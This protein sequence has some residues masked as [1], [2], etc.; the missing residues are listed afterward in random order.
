[1]KQKTTTRRSRVL[2]TLL[3]AAIILLLLNPPTTFAAPAR[4]GQIHIVQRGET[5]SSIAARYGVSLSAIT[6]ANGISNANVIYVG[7]SLT[8]PSGASGT[9]QTSPSTSPVPSG[10]SS[11]YTGGAICDTYTV[12]WGDN[13]STIAQRYGITVASIQ[14]ANGLWDSLIWP[15]LK[16]KIPCTPIYLPSVER[17]PAPQLIPYED[18]DCP[19]VDG[20]YQV[21]S[22]DTLSKIARRCGVTAQAIR[23][24]NS[25]RS[26]T[27]YVGQWLIIRGVSVATATPAS[28][29][30]PTATATPTFTPRPTRQEVSPT[31][32]PTS[33]LPNWVVYPTPDGK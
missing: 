23:E 29:Y 24:M 20:K 22:G 25:L 28:R 16:L 15:W 17:S 7:Q 3:F 27:I 10:G 26:D 9:S 5:L 13:L 32:T 2:T 19:L 31:A 11:G 6:Q 1:M 30:V 33:A 21:R 18:D 14:Q 12:R 8:I 4:Q